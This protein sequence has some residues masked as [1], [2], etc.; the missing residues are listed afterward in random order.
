MTGASRTCGLRRCNAANR[1]AVPEMSRWGTHRRPRSA[2][3]FA[4][5]ATWRSLP[6]RLS[7]VRTLGKLSLFLG[8]HHSSHAEYLR[9]TAEIQRRDRGEVRWWD[10]AARRTETAAGS[11]RDRGEISRGVGDDAILLGRSAPQRVDVLGVAEEHE[12]TGGALEGT[13]VRG[14]GRQG[15][16]RI[17]AEILDAARAAICAWGSGEMTSAFGIKGP[18]HLNKS[19][20]MTSSCIQPAPRGRHAP[21]VDGARVAERA[22]CA[23]SGAWSVPHHSYGLRMSASACPSIG[24]RSLILAVDA[25]R[26]PF[27][28]RGGGRRGGSPLERVLAVKE[29]SDVILNDGPIAVRILISSSAGPI[30][31]NFTFDGSGRVSGRT[32]PMMWKARAGC[33]VCRERRRRGIQAGQP[34]QRRISRHTRGVAPPGIV[35]AVGERRGCVGGIGRPIK[36]TRGPSEQPSRPSKLRSQRR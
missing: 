22:R 6:A 27:C 1:R 23:C 18:M 19:P 36:K 11:R 5:P 15:E 33:W 29:P 32:S 8:F 17:P 31:W 12:D 20:R 21:H 10:V 30:R 3:A 35:R 14:D 25:S 24:F 4:A 34:P 13:R 16:N 26:R 28:R 9:D 7:R 2:P